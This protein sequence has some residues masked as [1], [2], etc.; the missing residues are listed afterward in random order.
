MKN[1][2]WKVSL[3]TFVLKGLLKKFKGRG[4]DMGLALQRGDSS[5]FLILQGY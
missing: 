4:L 3:K 2:V 1:K 5:V